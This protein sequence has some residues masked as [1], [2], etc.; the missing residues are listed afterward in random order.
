MPTQAR[1][2]VQ[3]TLINIGVRVCFTVKH[4]PIGCSFVYHSL[5][6]AVGASLG[7]V[8][9]LIGVIVAIVVFCLLLMW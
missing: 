3:T 4:T 2:N 1:N 8:G 9:G 6:V 7:V 5:A